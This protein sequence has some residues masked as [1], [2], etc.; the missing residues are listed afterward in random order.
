MTLGLVLALVLVAVLGSSAMVAILAHLLGRIQLLE[1]QLKGADSTE[2]L[3]GHDE[4]VAAL[5]ARVTE[6]EAMVS[7]DRQ[8]GGPSAGDEGGPLD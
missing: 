7:F 3:A 2:L 6:L 1:Q 8:L 4:E 5:R